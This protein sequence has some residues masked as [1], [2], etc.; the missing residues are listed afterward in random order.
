MVPEVVGEVEAMELAVPIMD[1]V[2]QV[3]VDPV[4]PVTD[5]VDPIMDLLD[6]RPMA[7][8]LEAPAPEALDLVD[9][10]AVP[11]MRI[12]SPMKKALI[13]IMTMMVIT[14]TSM[15]R[16]VV[17]A[18]AG[19][20]SMEP[21]TRMGL[22][23]TRTRADLVDLLTV[24]A[25]MAPPPPPPPLVDPIMAPALPLKNPAVPVPVPVLQEAPRRQQLLKDAGSGL[26]RPTNGSGQKVVERQK[27]VPTMETP[28]P[29][30]PH[31]VDTMTMTTATRTT[32]DQAIQVG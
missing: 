10:V 13:S 28:A 26:K 25:A 16:D 14:M 3:M 7:K 31:T 30:P 22:I 5:P 21:D 17:M 19:G 23:L 20:P 9:T 6:L 11:H 27:L 1:L 15:A 8:D 12:Q 29:P 18:M 32:R 24:Q 4:D 2:D